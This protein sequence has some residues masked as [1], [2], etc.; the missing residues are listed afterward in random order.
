MRMRLLAILLSALGIE[1]GW[2]HEY[3]SE[4]RSIIQRECGLTS[5]EM[6]ALSARQ[7]REFS[8]DAWLRTCR[9]LKA[10]EF[11][12]L[13]VLQKTPNL[14]MVERY[15]FAETV[16]TLARIGVANPLK[17]LSRNPEIFGLNPYENILRKVADLRS[18]GFADPGKL[19]ESHPGILEVNFRETIQPKLVML[20][21]MGIKNVV[22]F[23]ER[24]PQILLFD[25]EKIS[26]R[27]TSLEILGFKN[28]SKLV[29]KNPGLLAYDIDLNIE[30]K[31]KLLESY[32]FTRPQ[33][34][35]EKHPKL[36]DLNLADAIPQKIASL[37]RLGFSDPISLF[38]SKPA[39]LALEIQ[40]FA[41]RV[42]C[43]KKT[44]HL[45]LPNRG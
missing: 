29:E 18:E 43:E 45:A 20:K 23:I 34:L 13:S 41:R 17:L 31:L 19:V 35:V 39:I 30:F 1:A 16:H 42:K 2:A 38:N 32:G 15:T 28:V 24:R 14:P 9:E 12:P 36:L 40:T 4:S 6:T 44:G 10:I 33:K 5:D 22:R 21:R 25:I 37:K 27:F 7:L 3:S 11:S 26:S 8:V